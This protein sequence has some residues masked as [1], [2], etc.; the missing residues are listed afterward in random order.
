MGE[1]QDKIHEIV[2]QENNMRKLYMYVGTQI[3]N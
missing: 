1:I 2:V 3:N